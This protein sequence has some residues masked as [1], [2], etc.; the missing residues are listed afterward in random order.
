MERSNVTPEYFHLLRIPL[1]RGRLFSD[2]D[3]EKAPPVAVVN[4]AFARTYWPDGDALGKRREGLNA[5]VWSAASTAWTT[6]IGVVADARTE[7]LAE[8]SVPQIYLSMYQTIQ[9]SWRSFSRG[10][11]DP[12]AIPGQVRERC[13]P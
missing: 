2:S 10:Q 3:N 6:V 8:A 4:Q 7:S 1:L 11:L 9:R 5:C 13:S 12:S